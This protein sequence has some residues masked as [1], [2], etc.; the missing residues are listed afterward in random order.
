M[1]QI[2]EL[3]HEDIIKT[4]ANTYDVDIGKVKLEIKKEWITQR[5]EVY[6]A[7]ATIT[8]QEERYLCHTL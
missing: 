4:I 1:K 6:K 3:T 2:I 5:D 7:S 8:L